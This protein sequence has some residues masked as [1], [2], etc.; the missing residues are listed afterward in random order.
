M[1][2]KE[3]IDILMEYNYWRRSENITESIPMTGKTI[4]EAIDHAIC[5][6][7]RLE[8]DTSEVVLRKKIDILNNITTTAAALQQLVGK[9]NS[10]ER[11]YGPLYAF[12]NVIAEKWKT[13]RNI[14]NKLSGE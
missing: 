14:R 4:E 10:M 5:L 7:N 9:Y 2:N 12:E 8:V 6:L 13:S 11:G 3:A 1:T